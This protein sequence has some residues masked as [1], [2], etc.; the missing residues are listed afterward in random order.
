M[1][2]IIVSVVSMALIIIST[3][4]VTISTLQSANRMADAWKTM[5]TRSSSIGQ[6]EIRITAP[7]DYTGGL[8][9]L[10]V[11]NEGHTNLSDFTDWDVILQYQ[12]GNSAY[13]AYAPGGAPAPGQW[14][15]LGI[16]VAD[17]SPEVF[18][19]GIL[20]PGEVMT[21]SI[22]PATEVPQDQMA[23]MTVATPNGITS[24]GY[25]TRK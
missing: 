14:A 9:N 25:V 12:S 7:T 23:R 10:T 13:L 18:D 5:E 3:L 2:T 1:E 22:N 21:V 16:R 17:G 19:P 8:I 11:A 24:Q 4:T 20:N 15:M 6:T